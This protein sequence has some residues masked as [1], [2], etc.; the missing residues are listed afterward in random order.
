MGTWKVPA[1]LLARS[2][3]AISPMADTVEALFGLATPRGSLQRA[4][5]AAHR[6][7]FREM[8]ADHPARAA[9]L[10]HSRRPDW[11]ADFLPL[12][13]TD[14]TMR[15]D[16]EL[17]MIEGLGD[18]R[19]RKDLREV[20]V[21][22]L[23]RVLTRPGLTTHV[24]GLLDW[25]WT[26]TLATDWPRRERILRGDIVS[27]TSRLASHG[28]ASVLRDLGRD[29]EWIG[30]GELRINRYGLPTRALD[31]DS[32]LFFVPVNGVG[33]SVGWQIPS[34]YAVYY[35]VTGALVAPDAPARDGLVRLV[36]RNRAEVLAALSAPTSTSQLTAATGLGLGV[37]GDHLTV[38][39]G[40]GL[41]LRR[42]SGREVLYWR[43][44]LGEAL[45]ASAGADGR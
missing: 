34:R 20:G 27:R 1:D 44:P 38:L 11:I 12:P 10:A 17:A 16:D 30:N 45:V 36:G 9:V 7:A 43:T 4:F 13:P 2:R 14:T 37:V 35:P 15:F 31:A 5:A 28:W 23:P 39:L 6:D 25:V 32:Q 40:A 3:F 42:R 24:T 19:I 8:L 33:S 22:P 21:G 18:A 26:H 41:V 29:R